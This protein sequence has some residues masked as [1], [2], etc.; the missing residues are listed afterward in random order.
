ME[1]TPTPW[2]STGRVYAGQEKESI[3]INTEGVGIA[4][5]FTP[6]GPLGCNS[7]SPDMATCEANAAFIV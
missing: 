5:V 1:H 7:L 3:V 6:N 4:R 2:R